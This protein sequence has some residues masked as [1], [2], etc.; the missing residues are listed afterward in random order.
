MFEYTSSA[1]YTYDTNEDQEDIREGLKSLE[2][3]EGTIDW[4]DYVHKIPGW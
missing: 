3:T 1:T 4:D 2:D